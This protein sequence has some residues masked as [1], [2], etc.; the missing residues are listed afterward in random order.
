MD[1][2]N[3]IHEQIIHSAEKINS[4][5]LSY[6]QMGVAI[7]CYY[8]SR[9]RNNKTYAKTAKKLLDNIFEHIDTIQS[10]D[11]RTG[12]A[13]I[14]LGVDFLLR[15]N[16]LKGNVN[17]I[18]TDMDDV[19]FRKLSFSRQYESLGALTLIEVLYYFSV[20]LSCQKEESEEAHL[21][22]EII[23][24]TIN[25]IYPK[26]ENTRL[27]GRSIYEVN[28]E[29]PLFMYVASKVFH[30]GFYNIRIKNMLTE[31]SPVI[32]STFPTIHANRL[33][34]LWGMS[35]V[36]EQMK[37]EGWE[38]HI[39]LLK[40][41]LSFGKIANRELCD[42][43]IFFE[44]GAVSLFFLAEKLK[45]EFDRKTIN[46]FQRN[47]WLNINRSEVWE[48]MA[49]DSNFFEEH[50]GLYNGFCGIAMLFEAFGAVSAHADL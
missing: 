47:L 15:N 6:G 39:R 8:V 34:L 26:L 35:A 16:Y 42:R 36:Q 2:L 12:I 19:I 18:L 14:G 45:N 4:Y 10:I 30:A 13:G 9:T 38:Q 50:I 31:L 20:R 22:R 32:L 23:I 24:K 3:H 41:E 37:I 1:H 5:D 44:D 46:S 7:Y 28:Y 29:L 48:L 25:N 21:F 11:I 27:S 43:N 40:K 33:Y 17:N 49:A